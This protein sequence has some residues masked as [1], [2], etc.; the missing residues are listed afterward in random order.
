MVEQGGWH[1]GAKR[2]VIQKA[3]RAAR[4]AAVAGMAAC[5]LLVLALGGLNAHLA[6][7]ADDAAAMVA[8]SATVRA[9]LTEAVDQ[10][11][12]L[13]RMSESERSMDWRVRYGLIEAA[14]GELLTEAPGR[15]DPVTRERLV[16]LEASARTAMAHARHAAILVS[17]G[18]HGLAMRSLNRSA[19]G[20]GRNTL[21]LLAADYARSVAAL[22]ERRRDKVLADRDTILLGLAAGGLI[23]LAGLIVITLR[24][25][26]RAIAQ[27]ERD[28]MTLAGSCPLTTLPNRRALLGEIDARI[29]AADPFALAILDLQ[30]FKMVN[31]AHGHGVGDAVLRGVADRLLAFFNEAEPRSV[32]R[33][34]GDEFAVIVP[35]RTE[36]GGM[37]RGLRA[38][39]TIEDLRRVLLAPHEIDGL[40][41]AVGVIGGVAHFPQHGTG[42]ETIMRAADMALTRAH[43]GTTE[44]CLYDE[45]MDEDRRAAAVQRAEVTRAFG[46]GEFVPYLQPIVEL[47]RGTVASFEML[48]RWRRADRVV[49]PGLFLDA[50]EQAGL[51]DDFTLDLMS[52]VLPAMGEWAQP[53]CVSVNLASQ[54]V[55]DANFVARLCALVDRHGLP[56][57]RIEIELLENGIF[58]DVPAAREALDKLRAKGFRV[59]LD[60]F[61]IGHSNFARLGGIGIDKLKI[62]RSFVLG[63]DDP[64]NRSIVRAALDIS[65]TLKVRAVAEGVEDE[66]ACARLRDMGCTH[67]Q[68][69]HFARPMPVC[70]ASSLLVASPEPRKPEL[71]LA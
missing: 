62:D 30:R 67:A 69:F 7:R 39:A 52:K 33:L 24:Q 43:E 35:L 19:A 9:D 32:A 57:E 14:I 64:L 65:S 55:Q 10:L 34:G 29:G 49:G 16:E 71:R 13:V 25:S 42:V 28:L 63:L 23:F 58:S 22:A 60:D 68:G 56:G 36:E 40:M 41:L 50:V 37:A 45:T 6:R 18:E 70:E 4:R 2:G 27:A 46:A 21:R 3:A 12:R 17:Y 66:V 1:A 11:V 44:L 47:E 59:A 53:L 8:R 38:V 20:T 15:S 54:Q 61:G 5:F 51:L 48:A 31:D 26:E